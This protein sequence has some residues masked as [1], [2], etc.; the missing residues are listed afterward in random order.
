[1]QV[2]ISHL[3]GG[4]VSLDDCA[5]FSGPM[6]EAIEASELLKEAY[7]LEVSSPGIGDHLESDRDFVT[8]RGFPVEVTSHNTKGS[9]LKESGLLKNRSS[10]YVHLN[11][12]GRIKRIPRDSVVCV[13]LISPT[14]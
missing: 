1:M 5:R 4:D 9:D 12:R 3:E 13:R 11:I 14:S 10:E 8:F 2:L 7:V 6:G